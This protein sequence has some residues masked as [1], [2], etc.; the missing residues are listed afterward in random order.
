M[1]LS[2]GARTLRSLAT[3]LALAAPAASAFC[4][5]GDAP[6]DCAGLQALYAAWGNRPARWA[7]GAVG[8]VRRGAAPLR[9]SPA[10]R[11]GLTAPPPRS[12]CTWDPYGV[13]MGTILCDHT[14]SRVIGLFLE[15]EARKIAQ[16][17]ASLSL[18]ISAPPPATR[19]GG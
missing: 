8:Y 2:P 16:L 18:V 9:S 1:A 3:L 4:I 7:T 6:G 5:P 17:C 19:R 11:V 15:G 13:G 10:A 12:V 14:N